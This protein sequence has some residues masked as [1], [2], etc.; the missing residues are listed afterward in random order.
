MLQGLF[1]YWVASM[2]IPVRKCVIIIIFF[3][4]FSMSVKVLPVS[5]LLSGVFVH[6]VFCAYFVMFEGAGV[7]RRFLWCTQENI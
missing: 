5:P 7:M 2:A 3:L 6:R 1:F 4:F